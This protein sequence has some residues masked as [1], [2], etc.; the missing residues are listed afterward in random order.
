MYY[1]VNYLCLVMVIGEKG[2]IKW[3]SDDG[4]FSGIVGI[5]MLI[6]FEK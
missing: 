3:F 2:D 4:E 5:F 6:V 1:K